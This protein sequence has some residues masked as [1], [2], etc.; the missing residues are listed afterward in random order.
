MELSA[1]TVLATV[2]GLG[3]L[4]SGAVARMWVAFTSELKDCKKD[5]RGLHVKVDELHTYIVGVASKLGKVEGLLQEKE[6]K[7]K[8]DDEAE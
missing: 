8:S 6:D 1:E 5:R 4:L 7:R 3:A 2:T